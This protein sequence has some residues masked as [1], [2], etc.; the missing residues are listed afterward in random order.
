VNCDVSP[1]IASCSRPTWVDSL[2]R[3]WH[4]GG[5]AVLLPPFTAARLGSLAY[6]PNEN[7]APADIGLRLA[8]PFFPTNGWE[9]PGNADPQ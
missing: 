9:A 3:F 2:G 4:R 5:P 6:A 1:P 8:A 7:N